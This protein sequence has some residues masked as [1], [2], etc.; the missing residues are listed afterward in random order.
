AYTEESGI[1]V[2]TEGRPQMAER[3]AFPPGEAKENWAILR[4][5]SGEMGTALPFDTLG[6]LRQALIAGVPHLGQ[7]DVV[8][9]NEWSRLPLKKPAKASFVNVITDFYLTNPIARASALMA[10]LSALAKAR[11]TAKV[12]AE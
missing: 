11:S 3:A 12:A 8:P 7:I 10:E 2:N 9:Q 4:A 5:L 1:F 6:Q